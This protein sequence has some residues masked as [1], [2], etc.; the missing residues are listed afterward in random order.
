M[1]G[2]EWRGG[3]RRKSPVD[4]IISSAVVAAAFGVYWALNPHAGWPLFPILFAGVFPALRGIRRLAADRAESAPLKL[5]PR[6]RE[7][8]NER[9]V[10]RVARSHAGRVT[11]SLVTLDSDMALDEAEATL[12]ALTKKGHAVMNIRDDGRIDYEF[13]E[14]LISVPKIGEK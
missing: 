5:S 12:A 10:L 4:S 3:R 8:E 11:P 9:T 2:N 13:S 1:G 7:A 6:E 14:F